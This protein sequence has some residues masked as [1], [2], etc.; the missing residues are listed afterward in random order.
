MRGALMLKIAIT[1]AAAVLVA[2]SAW[3]VPAATLQVSPDT[4][5]TAP[6][7]SLKGDRLD[8]AARG[9]A[10]AERAWPHYD[11]TCLYDGL[12]P[13][14]TVRKVRTVFTDRFSIGE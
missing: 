5:V 14:N 7:A 10:C 3:L 9:G 1:F 2:S 11:T 4:P 12:R 13:A 8:L 6:K